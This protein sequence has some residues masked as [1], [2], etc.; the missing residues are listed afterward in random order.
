MQI[1]FQLRGSCFCPRLPTRAFL[2]NKKYNIMLVLYFVCQVKPSSVQAVINIYGIHSYKWQW[3]QIFCLLVPIWNDVCLFGC[4]GQMA[5]TPLK[6]WRSIT[7]WLT[8]YP[9]T[10]RLIPHGPTAMLNWLCRGHWFQ[11]FCSHCATSCFI[12]KFYQNS[13]KLFTYRPTIIM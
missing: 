11:K 13:V 12:L 1:T 5:V 8:Y 4:G 6:N 7:S 2:Y 3:P 10:N 9:H